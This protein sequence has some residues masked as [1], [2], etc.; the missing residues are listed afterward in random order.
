MKLLIKNI[1]SISLFT[2]VITS[3]KKQVLDINTDPNNPTTSSATPGLVLPSALRNLAITYNA[4]TI[5]N[6]QFAFAGI[7]LGH[8]GYSGNYAISTEN[9]SYALTN[10]FA[11]GLWANLYDNNNDFDFIYQKGKTQ[12]NPF[13]EGIGLLMKVYNFQTLVDNYNNVPYSTA[14]QGTVYS[15]PTY[16]NGKAVY[17]DLAKQIDAAVALF[18]T[19]VAGT[20]TGDI[21]FGG[22]PSKWIKF[23]NTVKLRLLLRQSELPDRQAYIA[24]EIAKIEG[25][26][27]DADVKI[28]PGYLNS[29]GKQNPLWASNFNTAGTYTQ[30]FF[31]AAQ[32]SI[33]FFIAHNDTI[34]MKRIYTG[35]G[36]DNKDAMKSYYPNSM[37]QGNYFGDQGLTNSKT[38]GFGYGVLRS[39]DQGS[40]IMTAAESYFLQAEAVVRGWIPGDAKALYESGVTASHVTLDAGLLIR[41]VANTADSVKLTPAQTAA[42]YYSQPGDKEVNWDA[43]TSTAEEIA[44]IIRQKWVALALTNEAEAFNDYRRL[45][46]PA[47]IPLSLSPFS[48]GKF[49]Q[50]LLYPQREYEV[51]S[52]NVLQQGTIKPEDKVWWIK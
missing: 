16:D 45:K 50:R 43:T 26:Y 20:I 38:S 10:N 18:K 48:T 21:M 11:A 14:L 4:P 9:L 37:Y 25:G 52:E 30:D 39:F 42:L 47:D 35:V 22:D 36:K 46:L 27:V 32:Y 34:R 12:G 6:N 44:I 13:F 15:K 23:A 8:I 51:N 1:L 28:N 29:D 33:D 19:S 2:V 24:T 7:W 49:P 40:I 3:C 41:N 31:R 17:D 5:G